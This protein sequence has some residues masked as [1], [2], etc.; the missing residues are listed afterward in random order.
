MALLRRKLK[1]AFEPKER[2]LFDESAPLEMNDYLA[3][4]LAQV[5]ADRGLPAPEVL[6]HPTAGPDPLVLQSPAAIIV[7]AALAHADRP[8]SADPQIAHL[9]FESTLMRAALGASRDLVGALA[10]VALAPPPVI[11]FAATRKRWLRHL[12][13]LPQARA[14]LS[15]AL[16]EHFATLQS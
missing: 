1:G 2:T 9:V 16:S 7:S 13:R 14:A 4:A 6:T 10:A 12:G 8:Q 3:S 11:A 5:C 15:Y